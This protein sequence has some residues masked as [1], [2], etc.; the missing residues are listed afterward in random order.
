MELVAEQKLPA[1]KVG[2]HSRLS[3]ADV[4]AFWKDR[5]DGQQRVFDELPKLD[6]EIGIHGPLK[7]VGATG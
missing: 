2:S 7:C 3:A 5:C 1:H 4:W 6:E